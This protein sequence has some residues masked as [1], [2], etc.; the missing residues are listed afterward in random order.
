[1]HGEHYRVPVPLLKTGQVR[2]VEP[3][4]DM[5]MHSKRQT[6]PNRLLAEHDRCRFVRCG[7]FRRRK[8]SSLSAFV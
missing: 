1:L 7:L 6:L 3:I 2:P 8:R 4:Q 5:Q